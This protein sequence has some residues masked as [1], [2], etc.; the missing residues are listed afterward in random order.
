MLDTLLRGSMLKDL[1][2][3]SFVVRALILGC[4]HRYGQELLMQH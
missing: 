3:F 2:P 1:C 4:P